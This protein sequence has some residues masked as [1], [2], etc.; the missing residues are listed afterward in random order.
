M[1]N[2]RVLIAFALFGG[3]IYAYLAFYLSY[4]K[5]E[6]QFGRFIYNY[7]YLSLADGKFD[8]PARIIGL[9][10]HY[11]ANGRAFVY[12]GL[13][14]V[15]IRFLAS[16]FLDLT[17]VSLA[18]FTIWLFTTLGT[19]VYHS[20]FLRT[21]KTEESTSSGKVKILVI[22]IMVWFCSPGFILVINDSV[23][24]EPIAIAYFTTAIFIA[25]F[26]WG[27]IS[28]GPW[29]KIIVGMAILAGI[30]VFARPN[31]AIGLYVGVTILA[32]Y[33][34]YNYRHKSLPYVSS[35]ML[36]LVAFGACILMVNLIRFGDVFRMHGTLGSDNLEMGF[37]FF[38]IQEETSP[39]NIAFAT[40]GRFN[41]KRILP[42][43]ML[44]IF[45]L[46]NH[47]GSVFYSPLNKTYAYLT[48]DVGFIRNELP[49]IGMLYIWAPWFA[50]ILTGIKQ[51]KSMPKM[52]W[53][54]LCVTT[55]IALLM[56]SYGTITLR[57]RVEFWP[58]IVTLSIAILFSANQ[59]GANK[60]NHFQPKTLTFASFVS[61][62]FFSLFIRGYAIFFQSHGLYDRWSY[63]TCETLV[64]AKNTFGSG[65]VERICKLKS[66]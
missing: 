22:S 63:E 58:L 31:I 46:P 34:V 18:P 44:Y 21:L 3:A 62:L 17:K 60:T 55:F 59:H 26:A 15:I 4:G 38:G 23:Y 29:P 66:K 37:T 24:H 7:Y 6:E 27:A 5:M 40:H 1:T 39:R 28:N 57:Y 56:A 49:H 20:V 51:M 8:I 2:Q 47:T 42:N 64:L 45:D 12:H 19:I 54:I 11:D 35:A 48:A 30:T 14:P 50:L 43:L 53:I 33:L 65:D 9:E 52:W 13:A 41:L 10:G 61:L 32:A 16:P 36:I 25:L